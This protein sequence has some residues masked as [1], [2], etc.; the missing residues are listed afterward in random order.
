MNLLTD[1][2]LT[3]NSDQRVSLPEL[4][5]AMTQGQVQGFPALRPHQR[6][7][8]HMFLVQLS[9][10]ALWTAK[11]NELPTVAA[12]WAAMLRGLT[13]DHPDDEPWTLV[14]QDKNKPAFMQAPVPQDALTWT[15]VRT[16]DALDMLITSKNH[17]LK[18]AVTKRA[19]TEDWVFALV[20][21]Q[22]CEGY[23]GPKNYGIAR[24]NG[25]HS[26]RPMLGLAPAERAGDSLDPSKWWARDVQ[27]LIA[28]RTANRCDGIGQVGGPALLWCMDWTEGAQLMLDDLDP[29]FIEICRRVRLDGGDTAFF[30]KRSNSKC[31]RAGPKELQGRAH[32]P[33]SP[34]KKE[35]GM[36]LTLG[37]GGDFDYR[38]LNDLLFS[39]N[40]VMPLLAKAG[41]NETGDMLL[42]AEAISRGESKTEGFRSRL[43]PVPS[44]ALRLFSS[45]TAAAL[46]KEQMSEIAS[47]GDALRYA[48]ALLASS[49]DYHKLSAMCAEIKKSRKKRMQFEALAKPA[50]KQLN[51]A[52][53]RAFFPSLWQRVT[54]KDDDARFA[55]KTSFLSTLNKAAESALEA[56]LPSV[57]CSA[58]HRT[59]ANV[60]ARRA[61]WS[62]LRSSDACRALF[63]QEN[64]H[65]AA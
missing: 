40:W 54:A 58:V 42:V 5:A 24:M 10:L 52:A 57:P 59:R 65:D 47:F 34:T 62:K 61:F 4:L 37:I 17:D 51:H 64:N 43:V 45:S 12:D 11:R 25:G 63:S 60:R 26:S 7:A 46:A 21:L 22:T 49:G 33:W 23:G 38:E 50:T 13:P 53:D 31:E 41:A 14:V 36:A 6:P 55:A 1:P 3:V 15:L 8:W 27:N 35:D 44:R 32:D 39:G 48:I 19:A 29:W 2:I 30:A 56:T 16:P 18:Q 20:S 9:A 28:S